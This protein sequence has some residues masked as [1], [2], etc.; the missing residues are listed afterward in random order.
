MVAVS[1]FKKCLGP[2]PLLREGRTWNANRSHAVPG[3]P[4]APGPALESQR[5]GW[6]WQGRTG[7]GR[8]LGGEGACLGRGHTLRGPGGRDENVTGALGGPRGALPPAA[9]EGP[10]KY[11]EGR[12]GAGPL[13]SAV[14]GASQPAELQRG[15][16]PGQDSGFSRA[17]PG[18]LRDTEDWA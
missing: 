12:G 2:S 10:G 13:G 17:P 3:S 6:R 18:G 9:W 8:R 4:V 16:R 1:I 7:L 14:S 5:G 15:T 11:E